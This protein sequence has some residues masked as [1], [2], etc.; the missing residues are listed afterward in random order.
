VTFAAAFSAVLIP[1]YSA[2]APERM[3]IQYWKDADTGKSQWIV[4]PASGRLP[5]TIR[6]AASFQHADAGPFPWDPEPAFLSPAPG[7]NGAAPTLTILE[8]TPAAGGR[9]YRA[10][11]RSERGAPEVMALFPPGAGVTTV[12]MNG[13]PVDASIGPSQNFFRGWEIYRCLTT[14]ATGV[15]IAFAL[16][17]GKS[18]EVYAV[19]AT[20]GLPNEG[21]FLVK[22]RPFTATPAQDGDMTIVSRRVQII[23]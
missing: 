15:E 19:D 10:L 1:A 22:A 16:P 3:N 8:S 18:L 7:L 14:P 13:H 23:P 9:N 20:D 6:G 17:L 4:Q 12:R 5:E 21:K 2:K 11:L